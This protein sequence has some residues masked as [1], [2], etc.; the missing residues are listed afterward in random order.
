MFSHVFKTSQYNYLGTNNTDSLRNKIFSDLLNNNEKLCEL[1][2]SISADKKIPMFLFCILNDDFKLDIYDSIINKIDLIHELNEAFLKNLISLGINNG[3]I[4][5]ISYDNVLSLL[6]T[7]I[8]NEQIHDFLSKSY[9]MISSK[10]KG[11]FAASE[12]FYDIKKLP[13]AIYN[14]LTYAS[15]AGFVEFK[16]KCFDEHSRKHLINEL[17]LKYPDYY[18]E[19][20]ER[21]II[22]AVLNRNITRVAL[23]TNNFL[24]MHL[25]DEIFVF[26]TTFNVIRDILR[27]IMALLSESPRVLSESN[28]QYEELLIRIE[29]ST[30]LIQ[31]QEAVNDFFIIV[32]KHINSNKEYT[33]KLKKV[34]D[35]VKFIDLKYKDYLLCEELLCDKFGISV[36]YLSRIFKESMGVNLS[37]Y[38]Q[39]MRID[40]A[41]RLLGSTDYTVDEIAKEIGYSGGQT[42]LRLFKKFEG[43]TPSSYKKIVI[44]NI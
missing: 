40:E 8:K 15:Y 14:A 11:T 16:G 43:M 39:M 1:A 30:T 3:E 17:T 20:Y 13:D 25:V 31:M 23:I 32:E 9:E 12:S 2:N 38:I 22:S 5:W 35:I 24:I 36:S 33:A 42:L 27:L 26:P 19:N 41:K 10:F 18:L 29:A 7:N 44:G 21:P 37:T 4:L 28:P 34:D 6:V